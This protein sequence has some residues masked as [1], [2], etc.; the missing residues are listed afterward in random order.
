MALDRRPHDRTGAGAAAGHREGAGRTL[1][2]QDHP[3]GERG[4]L[5]AT[6]LLGADVPSMVGESCPP[7]DPRFMTTSPRSC[8]LL[9]FFVGLVATP[10]HAQWT[11]RY[12]QVGTGHHVYLEGYE[13]PTL[14]SG[15]MDAAL[16]PDGQTVAIADR[17]WL[18]LMDPVTGVARQ[19]TDGGDLD[20]RPSWSPDGRRIAFVRDDGADT[21]IAEVDVESGVETVL[22][23]TDAIELDPHYGPDGSIWYSS[24]EGGLIRVWRLDGATRERIEVGGGG[25]VSRAAQVSPDGARLL[26]LRKGGGGGDGVFVRDL[27]T[28]NEI[29]VVQ[30]P[31]LPQ[32]EPALA[33]DGDRVAYAVPQAHGDGWELRVASLERRGAATLLAGGGDRLPLAPAWSPDGEWIWF[34]EADRDDRFRL[35]RVPAVGGRAEEVQVTSREWRRPRGTLRLTTSL[36][37][38]P[39]PVGARLSVVD[40]QGHPLVPPGHAARFDGQTGTVF[41]YSTGVLEMAVP[42]G[43]VTVK[44]ARGL[45]S[46]M[47]TRSAMVAPG[48]WEELTVELEPVWNAAEA[49]WLSGDQHFHLNY[50]GPYRLEPEDLRPIMAGEE[51]DVATPLVANLHERLGEQRYFGWSG[52]GDPP[53]VRFGQE[54]RSHFLGHI[55]LIG[56]DELFWPWVW[57]P[58]YSV[59]GRDDRVNAEV[60]AHARRQGGLASYVHPAGADPF[61]NPAAPG[62]PVELVADGILGDVQ[63][64]EIACL[65]TDELGTAEVWYHLLNLGW[66]VAA[67]S[68][69]DVM[70]NFYRTMAPGTTRT[71]VK[72]GERRDFGAYL[73]GLEAG[74]SFVTTGPLV[75]FEVEGVEPGG[76][77]SAEGR[78]RWSLALRSAVPTERLEIVVNGE[79]VYSV[80]TGSGHPAHFEGELTLPAGGWIAARVTGPATTQWPAMG[81]YAFAHTS[82]VWIGGVGSIDEVAEQRSA[83]ALAAALEGARAR[84]LLGYGGTDIPVLTARF[85]EARAELEERLSGG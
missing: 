75:E 68:G 53:L 73:D 79:V 42:A 77:I 20:S 10:A 1:T 64:L 16:S 51:L 39:V 30:S 37:G 12:T 11:H 25:R 27:A 81:S 2:R 83:A 80:D 60:T 34:S 18:W 3:L 85:D 4:Q 46:P 78:G 72:T 65:W 22:V 23:D 47:E 56:T 71:Y 76:V 69:S 61:A 26:Y 21:W 17:G 67:T 58:G 5:G 33:P 19:L 32:I 41:F 15:P 36:S 62:L 9:F 59:Y 40:E 31:L 57:G 52:G 66:P 24:G 45:A 29:P 70:L 74:R 54:V 49:G 48:G 14:T 63:A 84:L 44:V 55:G 50:G 8:A 43:E 28:G 82:P 13:M 6:G 7:L 35:Y 38:E